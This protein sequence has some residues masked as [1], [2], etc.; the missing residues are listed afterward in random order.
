MILYWLK[1][2]GDVFLMPQPMGA[3]ACPSF[4]GTVT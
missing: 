4:T 2:A 1:V 3:A